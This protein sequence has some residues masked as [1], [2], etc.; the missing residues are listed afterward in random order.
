LGARRLLLDAVDMLTGFMLMSTFVVAYHEYVHAIVARAVG[1]D[2]Y[3][4][5]FFLGGYTYVSNISNV[6]QAIAIG[7]SGGLACF[8]VFLYFF[9]WWLEDPSDRN[10]R[11]PCVYWMANQLAYG[12]LEPLAVF[13]VIPFEIALMMGALIGLAAM[14]GY[15]FRHWS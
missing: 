10:L 5:Y 8:A 1:C 3:V 14:L 15:M 4:V 9:K 2:A 13:A 11:P 7:L 12:S 6:L